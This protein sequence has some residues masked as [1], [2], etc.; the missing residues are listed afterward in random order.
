MLIV[1]ATIIAMNT[2]K[3]PEVNAAVTMTMTEPLGATNG[4][5]NV[6]A[7]GKAVVSSAVKNIVLD[8][9]YIR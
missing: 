4:V 6:P 5:D 2:K 8:T 9:C 1:I 7:N 3:P